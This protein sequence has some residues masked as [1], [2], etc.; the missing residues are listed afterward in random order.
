MGRLS[1][2]RNRHTGQ[3]VVL[4]ANGPSLNHMDL[5]FLRREVT[6]GLNKIHLGIKKFGFYPRYFVAVNDKV[7]AQSAL[8]INALN[9]VKFISERNAHLVPENALTYHI[10]TGNPPARF[11]GNIA[12]G[13]H[14]GWTV[15]YAAQQIAYYLGFKEVIIIGMDHR[16]EYTGNPNEASRLDGSDPNHFNPDYFGGGQT[17]DNPDLANSE[18]SYRIARAEFEKAGRRIIDATYKGACTIFEKADY[19]QLFG[20]D[21]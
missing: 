1:L 3:R 14:E 9:C 19:R 7:I 10:N 12:Q 21:K 17:W 6:I 15:T 4:V 13:V 2:L 20:L 8:Q 16:Y 11:C 18:E 5:A